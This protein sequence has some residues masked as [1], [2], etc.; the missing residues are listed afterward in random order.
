MFV[1]L[2]DLFLRYTGKTIR[3]INLG[4]YNYLGF[5]EKTGPCAT[6]AIDGIKSFAVANGSTRSEIGKKSIYFITQK[7]IWI[8]LSIFLSF[9]ILTC[10]RRYQWV[11]IFVISVDRILT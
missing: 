5:A 1:H 6:D 2:K 7:G 10:R 3:A 11:H 9:L 4:S 8:A